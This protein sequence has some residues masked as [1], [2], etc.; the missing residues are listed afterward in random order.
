MML[1]N[2]RI[3]NKIN[4]YLA[5]GKK[6]FYKI[7]DSFKP[8]LRTITYLD[9]K[10]F[11]SKGTSLIEVNGYPTVRC[12]GIYEKLLCSKIVEEL[13]EHNKPI[14]ID[15]GANIGLV[16]LYILKFLKNVSIIAFEP[17]EH[18]YKLFKKT[19][20]YNKLS[21]SI[22]LY[23]LALCN[24]DGKS[25][26][27][28]HQSMHS[29]GDGFLDTGRAGEYIASEV[30][31]IRLDKFWKENN[32]DRV[33]VLKI[34]TEGSEL[35]VLRGAI[36]LINEYKPIIFIEINVLNL[37]PY[38]YEI[39]DY[40]EFFNTIN[41]SLLGLNG[42]KLTATNFNQNNGNE[43]MFMAIPNIDI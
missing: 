6:I 40:F 25:S 31:S 26:F 20:E 27:V 5:R 33:N 42:V 28:C 37:K 24:N 41:Y 19:I 30:Q 34:D 2:Q 16:S 10:L 14:I 18:Q 38:P 17:G 3:S 9:Y 43:D 12:G 13:N 23:K 36:N 29:S 22:K 8:F 32:Y 15:V 21:E 39:K 11:Y 4:Y 1:I 7:T 35:W